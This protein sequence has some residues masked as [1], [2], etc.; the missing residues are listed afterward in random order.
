VEWLCWSATVL[1]TL[2]AAGTVAWQTPGLGLVG[3]LGGYVPGW[4]V[5]LGGVGVVSGAIAWFDAPSAGVLA[6]LALSLLATGVGAK[7]I[8]DQRGSLRSVGVETGW[9][10]YFGPFFRS[11]S[12][13]DD[14]V[15]YGPVQGRSPRMAVYRPT[16]SDG[17]APVIVHIHGGGWTSGNEI[18]DK[19]FCRY[20]SDR[21]FLVFS[22][23]YTLSTPERPTWDSA[24]REIACGLATPNTLRPG[25]GGAPGTVLVT[26]SSAGG[27]L[28]TLVANRISLGERFDLEPDI[29]PRIAAVAVN[30]PAV[31]ASFAEGNGYAF[32]GRLAR[33]FAERY[34]GGTPASA[35]ARYA[36]VDASNFLSEQ[37]PPTLL[38]YGPHD[39]L[40][41]QQAPLTYALRARIMGV[42]VSA[43][44]VPWTGHLMG[45]SGA[46]GRAVGEL[47]T[48]WFRRHID[49]LSF[50]AEPLTP[51]P[52]HTR[53]TPEGGW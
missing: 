22:P 44:P 47:T 5:V 51:S 9:R 37:S 13:P 4:L 31:D 52:S 23:T 3:S 32:S 28:A 11:A 36:A 25:S 53:D 38:V 42:E 30:I 19:A 27:N 39:W 7:V 20:L 35:P 24:P 10:D 48:T 41:P 26:G 29:I 16:R 46:A 45:L 40:V 49:R 14:I 34:T 15:I 8:R 2:L 43:I 50:D 17:P 12:G 21:G 6:A 33:R 18:G 1:A